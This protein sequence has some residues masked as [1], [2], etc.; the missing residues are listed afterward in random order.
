MDESCFY[1]QKDDLDNKFS[2]GDRTV[3]K[4][5]LR[6]SQLCLPFF[7]YPFLAEVGWRLYSSEA[8]HEFL[9]GFFRSGRLTQ[10][11]IRAG[12]HISHPVSKIDA[13]DEVI[14]DEE[15]IRE[16]SK[17]LEENISESLH[18]KVELVRRLFPFDIH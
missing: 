9:E 16:V 15:K 12:V 8:N 6:E 4:S 18:V 13:G 17:Q 2:Y 14:D 10:G 11:F 3:L 7:S 1:G 5:E